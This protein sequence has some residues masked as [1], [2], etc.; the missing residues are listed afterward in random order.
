MDVII[1]FFAALAGGLLSL[2]GGL[3]LLHKRIKRET[4]M[5]LAMPF[6]AGALLGAAFFDVLPEAM[7]EA[8]DNHAI[9]QWALVGFVFFFLME[10]TVRWF[11][12]HHEHAEENSHKSL[13]VL[14]DTIHNAIDGVAIG[15]AFLIDV[16][17]GVATTVAVAAHE[18]PQEI[19]D[20][21]LLLSKGMPARKVLLVN[22][23]SSLATV[24]T[25]FAA[26]FLGGSIELVVPYLLAIVAGCFIYIAASDIIP[27]IHE[28]PQRKADIQSGLLVVGIA[29][30]PLTGLLVESLTGVGH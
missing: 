20:F 24:V 4:I 8:G 3:L 18:I 23:A 27:D 14:G 26:Y 25:A 7:H 9:L 29:V 11:H 1:L 21:G 6:G 12:R 5:L 2:A 19:G 10:R 17:L 16:P 15:A 13:I 28:Q 22:L 30:V